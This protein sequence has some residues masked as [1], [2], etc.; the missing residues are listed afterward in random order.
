MAP[1]LL[2]SLPWPR[3][4]LP[5]RLARAAALPDP[6]LW[7]VQTAPGQPRD[8]NI[9]V[10]LSDASGSLTSKEHHLGSLTKALCR[11]CRE[12]PQHSLRPSTCPSCFPAFCAP[13]ACLPARARPLACRDEPLPVPPGLPRCPLPPASLNTEPPSAHLSPSDSLPSIHQPPSLVP[14]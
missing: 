7:H 14:R 2:V 12:Q 8:V 3:R 13:C 9:P 5:G 11:Q 1:K 10:C 4:A 6:F